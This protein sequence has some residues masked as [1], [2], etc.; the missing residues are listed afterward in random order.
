MKLGQ[1]ASNIDKLWKSWVFLSGINGSNRVA[2]QNHRWRWC[3]SLSSI[4]WVLFTLNSFH[5]AKQWTKLIM[6]KYWSGYVKLCIEYP[7]T[8][9]FSTMTMLQL[10]R[11]SLS[12]SFW[13]K[14]W[15]LKWNTHPVPLTWLWMNSVGKTKVYL[16]G[17][18]I[19][20]YWRL[21][22]KV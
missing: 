2:Y 20:V 18:K 22:K 15:L 17:T 8:I 10:T 7:P 5:K 13:P 19:S 6:W 11:Q 21:W 16:N 4:S 1:N 3:S 9:G 14:N 12:S